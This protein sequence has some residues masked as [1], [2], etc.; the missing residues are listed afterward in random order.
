MTKKTL[1]QILFFGSIWGIVE[2]SLGY[3]LHLLPATIAGS[4]LFPIAGLILYR[5]YNVT[6]SKT[7]LFYI[8][9]V[10]AMIKSVNFLLPQYSIF[11]TIN[12]MMSIVLESLL[13]VVVIAMITSKH[14]VNKYLALPVASVAWRTVFVLW[15]AVQ[16]VTTGNLAPYILDLSS[17][18]KFVLL[19]GLLSGVIGSLF[20]WIHDHVTFQ[21]PS[22]SH[23]ISLASFLFALALLLTY[24]L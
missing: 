21:L 9:L 3:V 23:R 22:L 7:A 5:A 20:V 1:T 16:Y 2:A 11:K 4:I 15:M 18:V 8:G 6:G 12:P 13:V 19:V 10:A 17:I 14:P 24:T